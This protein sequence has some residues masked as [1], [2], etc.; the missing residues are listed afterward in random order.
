MTPDEAPALN[1]AETLKGLAALQS[2]LD[3]IGNTDT[4]DQGDRL[5][6]KIVVENELALRD[7]I[8]FACTKLAL[9]A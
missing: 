8:R 7:L 6:A 2:A 9:E 1:R 3:L 4:A 5:L